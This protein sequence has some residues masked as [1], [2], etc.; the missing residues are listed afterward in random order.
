VQS[1]HYYESVLVIEK[2]PME[3]PASKRTGQALFPD[4]ELDYE[5]NDNRHGPSLINRLKHQLSP[6]RGG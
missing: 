2:R 1:I 4:Y 3:Q 5:P 6:K